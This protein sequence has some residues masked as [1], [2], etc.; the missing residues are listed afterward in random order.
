MSTHTSPDTS[1]DYLFD[2]MGRYR[3]ER[4]VAPEITLT[5]AQYEVADR[6][7]AWLE[8]HAGLHNRSTIAR[9]VK[10]DYSDV[11]AALNF[12]ERYTMV[13]ADGNKSWRK[14]GAR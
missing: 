5:D 14:W 6:I 2:S 4:F 8:A 7:V 1:N 13:V 9:A 12:M 10:A 3:R 11:A